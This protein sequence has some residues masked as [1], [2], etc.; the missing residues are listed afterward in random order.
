LELGRP[1]R[2][3]HGRQHRARRIE[4]LVHLQNTAV[5]SQY[6]VIGCRFPRRLVTTV[7]PDT[8][9]ANWNASP[10]PAA[11]RRLGDEWLANGTTPA[12]SVPSAVINAERNYVL[13]PQHPDFASIT[14]Q[15]PRAFV[16]DIRLGR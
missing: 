2:H 14:I 7:D 5:L 12:L 16:F 9:P 15:R 6:V 10:A 13:N 3:L 11:V 8:L 1:S 4:L